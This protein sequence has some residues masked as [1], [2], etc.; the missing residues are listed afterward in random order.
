MTSGDGLLPG[1][2]DPV[3]DSQE[4]FRV[5]MNA[6]AR[7]GIIH[8]LPVRP[9]PPEPLYATTGAVCLTLLDFETPLWIDPSAS[10]GRILGYLKFHCGCPFAR[11]PAKAAF[12]VIPD[13]RTAPEL[14]RFRRG[15]P[16][17]PDRSATVIIQVASLHHSEGVTLSGP[18][19]EREI[20]LQATGLNDAFWSDFRAN[21]EQFPLG[22]DVLLLSPVSVC[23]LPRTLKPGRPDARHESVSI[24][25]SVVSH[26][27][28]AGGPLEPKA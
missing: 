24:R 27:F 3:R 19:I 10:S 5:L 13:G 23:G 15:D 7:P 22:V 12:A 1:F 28:T 25:G 8:G 17:Y 9:K 11:D 14:G 16:L 21:G 6:T 20:Q 4:T 18:G 2:A 26:A